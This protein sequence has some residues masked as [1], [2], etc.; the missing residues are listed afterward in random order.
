MAELVLNLPPLTRTAL[1]AN[2]AARGKS[3]EQVVEESLDAAGVLSQVGLT[4][5]LQEGREHAGLSEEEAL[6]LAVAETR[7]ARRQRW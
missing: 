7:A 5:K 2:A 4:R 6:D 1:V 3:I